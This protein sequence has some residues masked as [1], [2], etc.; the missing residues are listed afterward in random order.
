[1]KNI[2]DFCDTRG[3]TTHMKEAFLAYLRSTYAQKFGTTL[4][5][6][7]S[8]LVVSKMNDQELEKAWAD[9]VSDFKRLISK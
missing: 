1:M 3:V 6:E 4:N 7:T 2:D 5:G 8:K 9:F